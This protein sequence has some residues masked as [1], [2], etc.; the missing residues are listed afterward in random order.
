MEL[1]DE[2]E[3]MPLQCDQPIHNHPCRLL[4]INGFPLLGA[5]LRRLL[6]SLFNTEEFMDPE[7]RTYRIVKNENGVDILKSQYKQTLRSY[8]EEMAE[9]EATR[10]SN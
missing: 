5:V 9:F 7:L 8:I 1:R 3:M 4:Y 2:G 10:A 6:P